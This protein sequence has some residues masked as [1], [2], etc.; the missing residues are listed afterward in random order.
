MVGVEVEENLSTE[1]RKMEVRL[2]E[3]IEAENEFIELAKN[4]INKLN[5]LNSFIEELDK[6]KIMGVFQ[7]A[8]K[9]KLDVTKSFYDTLEKMGKAEHEKSHLLES[10]G[11]IVLTLERRFQQLFS[12]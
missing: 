6:E 2:K 1:I 12:K 10:Y 8:L 5:E 9:L 4:C 7:K 11:S 3:F